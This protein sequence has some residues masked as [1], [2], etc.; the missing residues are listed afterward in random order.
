MAD[1]TLREGQV[2]DHGF[3]KMRF[4]RT[5]VPGEKEEGSQTIRMNRAKDLDKASIVLNKLPRVRS[6]SRPSFRALDTFITHACRAL[7]VAG[8]G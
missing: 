8:C 6:P 1:E 2:S 3:P 5:S 4:M 7:C